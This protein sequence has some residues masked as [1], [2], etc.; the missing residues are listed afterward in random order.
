MTT[1]W[2]RLSSHWPAGGRAVGVAWAAKLAAG[3]NSSRRQPAG[4]EAAGVLMPVSLAA[5]RESS[6]WRLA[7]ARDLMA[8]R[9]GCREETDTG[10]ALLTGANCPAAPIPLLHTGEVLRPICRRQA[11]ILLGSKASSMLWPPTVSAP[12]AG[13]AAHGATSRLW[14]S[15]PSARSAQLSMPYTTP[16]PSTSALPCCLTDSFQRR[17]LSPHA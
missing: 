2:P 6:R 11:L 4:G 14:R 9:Q 15:G 16:G 17:A 12:N 13:L 10:A 8:K 1:C 3:R 7:G 5:G